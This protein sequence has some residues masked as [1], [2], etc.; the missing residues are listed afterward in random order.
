M[1]NGVAAPAAALESRLAAAVDA[2]LSACRHGQRPGVED[3]AGRYPELADHLRHVLPALALLGPDAAPDGPAGEPSAV[4]TLGDFRLVREVGRG[5]M[6]I[7]Y[8]AEQISLGRRVALKV[9]PFAATMDPK[10]LQ[11]F[12]NEAKAAASL[13]HEHIVPVYA[14]GCERGVHYYAM[15]LIDGTTLAQLLP[16]LSA[17]PAADPTPPASDATG[18]GAPTGPLAA[19]STERGGPKGLEVYR[20]VAHLIAQAADALEHAHSL[21]I[22]HRD[23][24]PGNLI[25][26][27]G[28][29]V[30]VA[31][32]GLARFGPD[33]GLTMSGDLL[34]TLRYMAP[35]QALARHGLV[36]LRADV[37]GLGCTLYELLTGKPA[38]DAIDRADI[39]RQIA[40]EDPTPPRKLNKSVPAELETIALKCLV[41]NPNDRYASAAE[42]ADDLRRWLEHKTIKAKPPSFKQRVAK[43]A[44]RH[45]PVVWSGLA[46]LLLAA[47]MLGGSITW[48]MRDAAARR[49]RAEQ[50]VKAALDDVGQLQAQEQWPQALDTAKR[51][52][53]LL[54]GEAVSGDLHR[55]VEEALAGL[56]L[57][58]RLE[59]VR[60]GYADAIKDRGFDYEW[61]DGEYARVFRE[62]GIDPVRLG[63]EAV[64]R[65]PPAVRVPVAAALDDWAATHQRVEGSGG[66]GWERLLA[67]ARAADP[68]AWRGRLREAVAQKDRQALADLA[69]E[70]KAAGLPAA[71]LVRLGNALRRIGAPQEAAAVLRRAYRRHPGDFWVNFELAHCLADAHLEEAL[72]YYTAAVALRPRSPGAHND[73]GVALGKKKDVDEAVAAYLEAIRLK[74]D[75][76]LPQDNL[77]Q[78]LK[79]LGNLNKEDLDGMIATRR[80]A[81]RRKPD[82]AVAHTALGIA[83]RSKGDRDGAITAFREA[84]RLQPGNVAG[85]RNLGNTLQE[86][87]DLDGALAAFREAVRLRPDSA[88]AQI[89]L[90]AILLKKRDRDGAITAGREAVRLKPNDANAHKT[91]GNALLEKEDWD[92]AEAAWREAVRLDPASA[93]SHQNLG[94]IL[95][96]RADWDGAIA[97]YREGVRLRPKDEYAHAALTY[98]LRHKGDWDGLAA[99]SREW[100]RQVP[101]A[102]QPYREL[103]FALQAKGDRDGAVAAWRDGLRL[104]EDKLRRD[105]KNIEPYGRIAEILASCGDERLSDSRRAVEM[106]RKTIELAGPEVPEGIVPINW[107]IL[108]LAHYRAGDWADAI[109]AAEKAEPGIS[110]AYRVGKV[111][112]WLVLA[113]GHAR[114]GGFDKARPW[115]DKAVGWLDRTRSRDPLLCRL[116][117]EADELLGPKAA[118]KDGPPPRKD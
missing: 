9:L 56:N 102:T 83:L 15:Q 48:V 93:W 72:R 35:E 1:S 104:N 114:L 77:G 105:P 43:W 61:K 3:F 26:D 91:L 18:P 65:I 16:A 24:K 58:A 10:Q 94:R 62:A 85:H 87:G 66:R 11:R 46:V 76:T 5:G 68:D 103:G 52:E 32:F 108:G 75:D 99:A 4:G 6:G 59:E 70:S 112:N 2:F 23:V 49:E 80:E 63:A 95:Q 92:R 100:L 78:A 88:S 42:L 79:E 116:R 44:K 12:R 113:L 90:S 34:G 115:Y 17:P 25:V 14:V 40:F 71:S 55:R 96:H 50:V 118:P 28:G 8:E 97:R 98:P 47:A 13:H 57:V 7:V 27:T 22:V 73:L 36:D 69:A 106:A 81:I 111:G 101:A 41:K 31:D 89:D 30:W 110:D 82:D 117:A 107:W 51:A 39:L 21:G 84:V 64:D 86:K 45:Q 37:Y 74:P 38:V 109:A 20:T 67:A 19:L 60:L 33:A 29:K 54:A 53:G